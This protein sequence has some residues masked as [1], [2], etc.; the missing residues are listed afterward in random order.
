M[1]PASYKRSTWSLEM[2]ERAL[3]G[4][5][6][7]HRQ[8]SF[9]PHDLADFRDTPRYT[10][11]EVA[12]YLHQKPRTVH[13]WFFGR[14]YHTRSGK[15]FWPPL[16]TPAGHDPHGF[17]LSFFNLAEAHVLS[18]TRYRYNISVKK[19]REAI[20]FVY[21]QSKELHP[22]LSKKFETDGVDLFLRYLSEHGEEKIVNISKQGQLGLRDILDSYL[23]RIDRD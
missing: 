16:V 10:V 20:K 7:K 19:I 21:D 1:F 11:Q 18:A 2:V 22:L 6:G 4:P 8:Q 12:L 9:D 14:S 3:R 23:K 5:K 17:S 13:T 15:Q